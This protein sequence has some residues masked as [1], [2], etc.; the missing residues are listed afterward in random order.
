M[1]IALSKKNNV[2]ALE[3]NNNSN[4]FVAACTTSYARIELYKYLKKTNVLYIA[5]QIAFFISQNR[6]SISQQESFS[7]S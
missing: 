5:I 1:V 7:V 6:F 4:I 2:A 3:L